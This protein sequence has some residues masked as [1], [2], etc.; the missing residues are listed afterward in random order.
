VIL[1]PRFTPDGLLPVGDYPLSLRQ[2]VDSPLVVGWGDGSPW[3]AEWR[4]RLAEN[5]SVMVGHLWQA[6]I[7]EIFVDGSF[8]EE[9]PHPN[10]IDGYFVCDR[11]ALFDGVLESRLRALDPVWTWDSSRRYRS[12]E[13]SKRQL[14]MWHKYR[15]E[16]FPHV[17]QRTGIVD[18]F[19]NELEFPSAFR[20]SRN[21]SPKGIIKIAGAP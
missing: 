5:L 21:F 16:L 18:Q 12:S 15:I 17:G 14:P 7:R 1:L 20:L 4:R 9:K 11:L 19:G 10:D 2:L 3:D 6:G 13:S 8:V